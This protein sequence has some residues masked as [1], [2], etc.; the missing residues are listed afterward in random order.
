MAPAL[1]MAWNALIMKMTVNADPLLRSGTMPALRARKRRVRV[2]AT[3]IWVRSIVLAHQ[4]G[5]DFLLPGSVSQSQNMVV[6]VKAV[7]AMD[8]MID[9][10]A[11]L[12]ASSAF[13]SATSWRTRLRACTWGWVVISG[14]EVTGGEVSLT[15][16]WPRKRVRPIW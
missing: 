6:A 13:I 14:E 5:L 1:A 15:P 2:G 4:S 8:I 9:P 10:M 3:S 7:D 11:T 16:E 12:L